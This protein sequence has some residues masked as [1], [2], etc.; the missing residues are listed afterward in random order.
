M[1]IVISQFLEPSRIPH[2]D[3]VILI[4]RYLKKAL[5]LGILYR[6]DLH[7]WVEGFIDANW[8]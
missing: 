2:W 5:G 1:P 7:L 4:F 3:V 6:K 8:A